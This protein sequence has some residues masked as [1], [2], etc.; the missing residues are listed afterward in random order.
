MSHAE[1]VHPRDGHRVLAPLAAPAEH[2]DHG[3]L[4]R[5]RCGLLGHETTL[6]IAGLVLR[7]PTC[8]RCGADVAP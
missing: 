5:L 3:W 8:R 1:F 4:A 2:A 6:G 7:S